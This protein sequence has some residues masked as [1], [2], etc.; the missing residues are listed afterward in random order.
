M[1]KQS[2]CFG[3]GLIFFLD[4]AILYAVIQIIVAILQVIHH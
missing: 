1:R 4:L 2:N 3:C